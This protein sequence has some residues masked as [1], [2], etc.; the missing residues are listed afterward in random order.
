MRA[1]VHEPRIVAGI[2]LMLLATLAGAVFLQHASQRIS[3]WQ[4]SNSLAAGTVI[5]AADVHLTEVA[6]DGGAYALASDAVVGR[7]LVRDV[8]A[9]EL[10]ARASLRTATADYEEVVVPAAKLH[11]PPDT[12]RGQRVAVW[13]SSRPDGSAPTTT[14]RVLASARVL[15]TTSA[16][17]GAGQG[18]VLAVAPKDVQKL[19]LAIRS[20]D[21]DLVRVDAGR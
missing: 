17:V 1:L 16:D 18:V 11:L 5:A 12:R 20:G 15:G 21:I 4:F 19:V 8:T 14:A 9:G 7:Q 2:A 13:W 10:L 3:V 6:I